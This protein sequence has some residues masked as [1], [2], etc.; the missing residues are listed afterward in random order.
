MLLSF[1]VTLALTTASAKGIHQLSVSDLDGKEV[2]LSSFKGKVLLIVNTASQCGYTPQ[3]KGLQALHTR[4]A[5]KGFTVLGFPSNDF[6]AQEPGSNKD[7]KKFCSLNYG[8]NFPMFAKKPVKGAD[9]QPLYKIL[10]ETGSNGI[11][12]EVSW[13][14]EKFLVDKNGQI[15]ARFSSGIDPESEKITSAIE[16]LL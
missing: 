11:R 9:K 12:G 16:K 6:G 8:V 15:V 3:Y 13:N 5:A 10:T 7:I 4:Y 2:S 1:L 14:F